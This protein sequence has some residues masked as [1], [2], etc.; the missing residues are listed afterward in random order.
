M[1]AQLES[2]LR[3]DCNHVLLSC[4]T[5]SFNET[6]NNIPFNHRSNMSACRHMVGKK[7]QTNNILTVARNLGRD[8]SLEQTISTQD[9]IPSG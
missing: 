1:A 7:A 3:Q 6:C 9:S 4:T 8:Q 2:G 5:A